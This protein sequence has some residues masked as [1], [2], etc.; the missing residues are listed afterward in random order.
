MEIINPPPHIHNLSFSLSPKKNK[1]KSNYDP[2][3]D[4]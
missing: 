3:Q 1:Y 4:S 2:Q